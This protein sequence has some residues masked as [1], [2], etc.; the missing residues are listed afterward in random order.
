MSRLRWRAVGNVIFVCIYVW[1]FFLCANCGLSSEL[2]A[3]EVYSAIVAEYRGDLHVGE[4]QDL[5]ASLAIFAVAEKS[6]PFEDRIRSAFE[7]AE[8]LPASNVPTESMLRIAGNG[9][10]RDEIR[11]AAIN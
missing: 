4:P 11:V 2:K 8:G 5:V 7:L 6:I 3:S 10:E 9:S 1:S